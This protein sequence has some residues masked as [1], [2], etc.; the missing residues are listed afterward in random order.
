[1]PSPAALALAPGQAAAVAYTLAATA[2]PTVRW[3]VDG[4][5]V[6]RNVGTGNATVSRVADNL[7]L[8]DAARRARGCPRRTSPPARRAP[9][10]GAVHA[11]R[12][13]A[14][15]P[16]RDPRFADPQRI[17]AL[18]GERPG[19]RH[20]DARLA[21]HAGGAQPPD[22]L[23]TPARREPHRERIGDGDRGG[24]RDAEP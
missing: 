23:R 4:D 5:V 7:R 14:V 6:V 8:A 24:L 15:E 3:V 2:T 11:Q 17:A 18:P 12:R 9:P 21:R 10:A 19:H 1:S 13:P 22:L 16:R 20:G